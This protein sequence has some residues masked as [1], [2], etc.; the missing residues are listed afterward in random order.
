VAIKRQLPLPQGGTID[1]VP[2][3][4]R[5]YGIVIRM[6]SEPGGQH[7][8]P[9]FHAY[10]QGEA[11]VFSVDPV[12]LIAGGLPLKQLRLAEAWAELHR[13]EL[14]TAWELLAS[15]RPAG[16]IEPLK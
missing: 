3:L 2:E 16:R 12:E 15:G 11:A 8:V 7:N 1:A 4:S 14:E 10:S 5:F 6:F 13:S 9:H